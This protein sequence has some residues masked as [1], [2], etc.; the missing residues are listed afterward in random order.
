MPRRGRQ[1]I[2]GQLG[3]DAAPADEAPFTVDGPP[4]DRPPADDPPAGRPGLCLVCAAPLRGILPT[5]S[6]LCERRWGL[7]S[8]LRGLRGTH[9][10]PEALRAAWDALWVLCEPWEGETPWT[11]LAGLIESGG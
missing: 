2:P 9:P 3:L 6:M 1:P 8:A 10:Y 7:L 4:A 5:C 11:V